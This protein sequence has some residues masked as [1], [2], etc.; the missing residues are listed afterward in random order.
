M[1]AGV[2]PFCLYFFFL[3][4]GGWENIK[5]IRRSLLNGRQY[6]AVLLVEYYLECTTP[7]ANRKPR[8]SLLSTIKPRYP[9]PTLGAPSARACCVLR[10]ASG[11]DGCRYCRSTWKC[12]ALGSTPLEE[13][14]RLTS[15]RWVT[16]AF[17]FIFL[18]FLFFCIESC[19]RYKWYCECRKLIEC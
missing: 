4:P 6:V 3:T 9:P 19:P 10:V 5:L 1:Y 15:S 7:L 8:H 17:Y 12:R 11:R 18:C 16:Y 2:V 13:R 14:C